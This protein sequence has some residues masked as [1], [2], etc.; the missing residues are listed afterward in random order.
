MLSP[1]AIVGDSDGRFV[2][3][4]QNGGTSANDGHIRFY[5]ESGLD[6]MSIPLTKVNDLYF[7]ETDTC[8]LDNTPDEVRTSHV[9][10]ISVGPMIHK[11]KH[12]TTKAGQLEAELWAARL[13]FCGEWQLDN[14]AANADGLP[15]KFCP[16][17]LR[18]IDTK[19]QASV[20]KQPAKKDS[21]WTQRAGARFYCDFGF[22]RASTSDYAKPDEDEDRVVK[23]F[24]G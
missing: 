18:F 11:L 6:E 5:S 1:Q 16:H 10:K 9:N 24:D 20:R 12:P 7:C 19:E 4:S 13:G 22:L 14:I 23:S 2:T 17:P 15:P 3:W 8:V 21:E